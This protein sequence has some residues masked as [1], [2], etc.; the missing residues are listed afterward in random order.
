LHGL[1][2]TA[3][4]KYVEASFGADTWKALLARTGL[5]DAIFTPLGSY[6]DAQLVALVKEAE[7]LSNVPA[8]T[9]LEGF[10]EFLV[11]T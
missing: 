3:L 8:A 10:G 7:A 1:I 5:E 4:Q 9:L 11:P 2:H 6:P